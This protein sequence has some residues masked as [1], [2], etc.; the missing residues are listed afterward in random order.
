M[1]TQTN[2]RFL[3]LAL[4]LDAV[5]TGAVGLLLLIGGTFLA[6]LLGLPAGLLHGAGAGLVVFAAAV[7]CLGLR[8]RLSRVGAREVVVVNALWVLASVVVAVTVPM[9]GLGLA[10]VLLQAGAVA[11]FAELQVAGLRRLA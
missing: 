2:A 3:R 1:T 8:R 7:A 6:G 4:R 5:A 9:T 11:V 10:F